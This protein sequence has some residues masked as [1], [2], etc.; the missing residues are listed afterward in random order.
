MKGTFRSLVLALPLLMLVPGCRPKEEKVTLPAAA[1]PAMGGHAM[2]APKKEA[3][4]VVPES[5][6][7][8]WKAIKVLV[9]EVA[10]KKTSTVVVPLE[11][12]FEL[13]GTGL[14]VRVDNILPDFSMGEGVITSKSDSLTNPAAKVR[15][16]EGGKEM[17]KGWLFSLFPEAHAFEHS[18]YG[19]KL[20]DF[21]AAK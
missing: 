18:K 11:A 16:S 9:T 10:T 8:K 1:A 15:I 4:V 17:Y 3:T 5:Q 21:V 14:T 13:P 20:V 7:G 19:I 2:G 6:K 12:D